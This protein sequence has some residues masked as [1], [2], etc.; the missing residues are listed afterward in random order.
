[1]KPQVFIPLL[2]T[3]ACAAAGILAPRQ[4]GGHTHGGKSGGPGV[5]QL[6]QMRDMMGSLPDMM[7]I[8]SGKAG[9]RYPAQKA[10]R[11]EQL[12]PLRRQGAKRIK[13]TYGP[14]TLRAANNRTKMGNSFSLDPAGTGY[15]YTTSDDFPKDVTILD[16]IT[17]VYDDK[18][19]E[20]SNEK[21]LYNHHNVFFD[22][23]AGRP[24]PISCGPSIRDRFQMTMPAKNVFMG[25]A[26]DTT[27]NFYTTPDGKFNSGYYLSN[28]SNVLQMIDIVNY[29]NETR[30]VYT[31]SEMEY[32]SGRPDNL[33]LANSVPINLG[34][35]DG[36]AGK[37]SIM[38]P[39]AKGQLDGQKKFTLSGKDITIS[40]DGY[41]LNF[42]G[43]MH[44]GGDSMVAKIN[45]K[46][47]CSSKALYGG[48]GH[49]G[50]SPSGE[51]WTMINTMEF[52]K[53]NQPIKVSRGD[54]LSISGN[55]DLVKHPFREQ[56][57]GGMAEVMAIMVTTFVDAKPQ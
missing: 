10:Y 45:G 29:N 55:F 13:I 52:C 38:E 56:V 54:K 3:V 47:V 41:F 40:R 20:I 1:M 5:S 9:P 11:V 18:M 14:F 21:G 53:P 17:G 30:T 31:V 49:E 32:V 26:A 44:D 25:G 48:P 2:P 34:M 43:H 19:E 27:S 39:M 37:K 42:H 8:F 23:S 15:M 28:R 16:A 12:Q 50:K 46:E 7:S 22:L 35:C 33:L 24:P 4:M 51:P 57:N 36:A 6:D